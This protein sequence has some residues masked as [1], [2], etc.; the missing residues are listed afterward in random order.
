MDFAAN[1]PDA[2]C[3]SFAPSWIHASPYAPASHNKYYPDCN[4]V[5]EDITEGNDGKYREEPGEKSFSTTNSIGRS[6][7]NPAKSFSV[8]KKRYCDFSY[9]LRLVIDNTGHGWRKKDCTYTDCAWKRLFQ[10][11]SAASNRIFEG[12]K[13]NWGPDSNQKY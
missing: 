6:S 10:F 2:S 13:A 5:E 3:I 4:N 11:D 8:L 1:S 9:T 12:L 7:S